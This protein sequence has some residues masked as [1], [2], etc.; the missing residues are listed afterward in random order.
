MLDSNYQTTA[1]LLDRQRLQK[2]R[3]EAKAILEALYSLYVWD[4]TSWIVNPTPKGWSHHSATR[5]WFGYTDSLMNYFNIMTHEWISRGY[6]NTMLLYNPDPER[7][8]NQP[9]WTYWKPLHYS[10]MASLM[11]KDTTLYHDKLVYPYL[12]NLHGYIW[13]T[14][15]LPELAEK[16]NTGVT[17][18]IHLVCDPITES[19]TPAEAKRRVR[20]KPLYDTVC[21]AQYKR[22]YPQ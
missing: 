2:Q 17:V 5:M 1:K 4:G 16:I 9:S 15:V 3:M 11:R 21:L 20:D 19:I 10:H 8:K 12:Y 7:M 6:N 18:E 14:H 22:D 13:P